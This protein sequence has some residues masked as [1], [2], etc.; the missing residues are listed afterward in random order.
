MKSAP[1]EIEMPVVNCA[2]CPYTLNNFH[3]NEFYGGMNT[4]SDRNFW[5]ETIMLDDDVDLSL[6]FV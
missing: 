1:N 3:S 5:K 6:Q 2:R 4:K